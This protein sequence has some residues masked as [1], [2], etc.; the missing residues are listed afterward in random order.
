MKTYFNIFYVQV[1]LVQLAQIMWVYS[2]DLSI[3]IIL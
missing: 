2:L 3:P 1:N